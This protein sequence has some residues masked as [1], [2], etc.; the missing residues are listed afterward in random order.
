MNSII[1]IVGLNGVGKSTFMNCFCGREE[2]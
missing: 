2:I 1:G